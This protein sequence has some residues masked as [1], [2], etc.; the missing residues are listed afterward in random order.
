MV[1]LGSLSTKQI[2]P[3]LLKTKR[4]HLAG[5]VTGTPEKEKAWSDKYKIDSN[6]IYNYQNFDK[7]IGDDSIDV[8][9]VVLPNSMHEEFTIRAAKAGKLLVR[10]RQV[11]DWGN[12]TF[13]P[14]V[15]QQSRC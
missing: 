3:G 14:H 12:H 13:F 10:N 4:C 7:I 9:Y 11:L 1:G 15:S 5:I 8:V 6:H 2:A